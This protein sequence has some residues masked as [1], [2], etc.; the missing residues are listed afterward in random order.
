MHKKTQ[1]SNLN[2]YVYLPEGYETGKDYPAVIFFPGIGEAGTN[3]SLLLVH[4][5]SRFIE[6]GWKPNFIVISVQPTYG[7]VNENIIYTVISTIKSTYKVDPNNINLTG[8]S[9][10]GT[11][12]MRF[13]LTPSMSVNINSIVPLSSPEVP[14]YLKNAPEINKQRTRFLGFCGI[15]DSHYTKMK[16]TIGLLTKG[17][18]FD[19]PGGH[20][21]WNDIYDPK[22]IVPGTNTNI[23][24]WMIGEY[25][26][27]DPEPENPDP[28]VPVRKLVTT[29]KIY[30]NGDVEK[31]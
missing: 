16:M 24:D 12:I 9:A 21:C 29:I 15:Q 4:G 14:D 11:G 17:K 27:V 20:C 23:Y 30:D 1:I 2:A 3:A 7:W 28:E 6:Q 10:G 8:L 25:K 31:I 22:F 19:R 5:P 13:G 18:F 26:P